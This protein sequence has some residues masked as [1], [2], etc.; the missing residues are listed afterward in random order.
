MQKRMSLPIVTMV[1]PA[2]SIFSRTRKDG[3]D[4]IE[5]SLTG[6][7]QKAG[8]KPFPVWPIV[9]HPDIVRPTRYHNPEH[10]LRQ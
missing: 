10:R 2:D 9:L 4:I 1:S 5:E 8:T 6:S 7:T 3:T